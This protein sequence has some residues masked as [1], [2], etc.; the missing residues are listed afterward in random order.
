[1]IG[2]RIASRIAAGILPGIFP[3]TT[4]ENPSNICHQDCLLGISLECSA[5]VPLGIPPENSPRT[6]MN[7]FRFISKIFTGISPVRSLIVFLGILP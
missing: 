3:K 1:M 6:C 4:I 2:A 7:L 5:G